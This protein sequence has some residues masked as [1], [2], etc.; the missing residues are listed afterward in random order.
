[1]P[2][3]TPP[4]AGF[5]AH[6][7]DPTRRAIVT[8][9]LEGHATVKALA[10]DLPVSQPAISQHL[11]ILKGAGLVVEERDGK[12][13]RYSLEP[14]AMATLL[15]EMDSFRER[16]SQGAWA[17]KRIPAPPLDE[18]D[19]TLGGWQAMQTRSEPLT[20]GILLRVRMI[21][22][23]LEKRISR[24]TALFGLSTVEF[25]LLA[26]LERIGPP[27]ESTLTELSRMTLLSLPGVA[28]Y[29]SHAEARQLIVR[30][31]NG[32]DGRSNLLRLTEKGRK[33]LHNIMVRQ[34]EHELAPV[35]HLSLNEKQRIARATRELLHQ[36]K[37]S[38]D[39]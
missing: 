14:G 30:L 11:K 35:F 28:K 27:N 9:L 15:D 12:F 10:A 18:V 7:G 37:A 3:I 6:I 26:S 5:F 34:R 39:E 24:S 8:K 20:L 36:L 17:G 21:A 25:R 13:H 23:L 1:M 22:Q 31:P 16:V 38:E 32:E 19:Q 4:D 29:L 33:T 2:D